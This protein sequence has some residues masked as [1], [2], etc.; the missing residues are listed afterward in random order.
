MRRILLVLN[1]PDLSKAPNITSGAANGSN[2]PSA[3]L[4]AEASQLSSDYDTALDSQLANVAGRVSVHLINAFALVDNAVADPAAFGL[5]NVTSPVWSGNFTSAASGTLAAI[6]TAAQDQYLF[7]DELHPTETGHQAIAGAASDRLWPAKPIC[8]VRRHSMSSLTSGGSLYLQDMEAGR[9][10]TQILPGI[11]TMAFTDGTGV[12][13]PTGT[14][15]DVARLYG[16]A[17]ARAPDVA[18]LEHWTSEIDDSQVSLSAVANDLA[19]SPEFIQD[20]GSLSDS[21]FVNQLYENALGRPADAAGAQLWEGALGSGASRGSVLVGITQSQ[22]DKADTVSTAGDEDNA[23]VYRLYQTAFARA[24]DQ[25]GLAS[26]SSAL[27]NGA[28]PTQVAQGFVNSA[29]F[30][31]DY[32]T[33]SASDFVSALYKNALHR[34]ADPAGLQSWTNALQ[35]GA[36]QASVLIGFSDSLESREQ[37][38]AATHANWVF[39]PT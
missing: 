2:V 36:S 9:D 33:L 25:A 3:A 14:A 15:E 31:Q 11:T 24:P 30:Q 17:L 5:T 32:G 23:E 10:G 34:A 4:D 27:A 22:E 8:K 1:V 18:G 26:W 35:Q 28:T 21:A 20:Y 29:E 7:W 38:A 39:I 13:D 19:T 12:F 6:G 37:T 16:A